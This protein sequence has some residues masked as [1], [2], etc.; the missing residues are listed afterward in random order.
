MTFDQARRFAS[1]ELGGA[2]SAIGLV[3]VIVP[4]L[5]ENGSSRGLDALRRIVVAAHSFVTQPLPLG[6]SRAPTSRGSRSFEGRGRGQVWEADL[7]RSGLRPYNCG[8]E[9]NDG[10][11]SGV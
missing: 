3:S 2:R 6:R 1:L 9:V 5:A 7:H 4:H 10:K 8:G 11:G